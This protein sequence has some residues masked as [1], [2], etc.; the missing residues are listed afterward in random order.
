M[1]KPILL[2]VALASVAQGQS[3]ENRIASA[4]GSVIFRYET[5]SNVCGTGSSIEISDDS[6]SGWMYR[7]KRSGVHVGVRYSNRKDRCEPGP[8]QVLL[9]RTDGRVAELRLTVGGVPERGD[10]DLGDV[11]PSKAS[12]YLLSIAPQLTGKAGDHAV[13]GAVI[14]EGGAEW[15]T[16]MR[17]ARDP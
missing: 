12:R 16:L 4:N 10:T 3:L 15:Q 2:V 7:S 17:I 6:S 1:R 13:L 9:R 8:A 11:L 5:R 14:A